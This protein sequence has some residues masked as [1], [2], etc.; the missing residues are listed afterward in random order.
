MKVETIRTQQKNK[1]LE[2]KMTLEE[3]LAARLE[4][5]TNN[6]QKRIDS[7]KSKAQ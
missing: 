5:A 4:R 3:R 1:D 7:V 6:R 2:Q